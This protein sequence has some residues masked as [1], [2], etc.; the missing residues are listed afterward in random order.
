[1]KFFIGFMAILALAVLFID[2]ASGKFIIHPRTTDAQQSHKWKSDKYAS[3]VTKN[4]ELAQYLFF[5]RH[6]YYQKAFNNSKTMC[7]LDLIQ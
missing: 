4:L 6:C 1:M 3:A 2:D 7:F 5:F